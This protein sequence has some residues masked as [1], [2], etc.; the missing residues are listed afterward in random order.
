MAAQENR[1]KRKGCSEEHM[2]IVEIIKASYSMFSFQYQLVIANIKVR[3]LN[4]EKT[5]K[6]HLNFKLIQKNFFGHVSNHTTW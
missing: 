6:K 1:T 5:K 3:P 2:C 4:I